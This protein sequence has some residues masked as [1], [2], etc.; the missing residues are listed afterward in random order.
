MRTCTVTD[1]PYL[2]QPLC[3]AQHVQ[4][5]E[6]VNFCGRSLALETQESQVCYIDILSRTRDVTRC[7]P[8]C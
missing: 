2:S 5:L 1:G 7:P 4:V 6:G 8:E 3:T